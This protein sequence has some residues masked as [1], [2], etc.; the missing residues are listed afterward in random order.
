MGGASSKAARKL[1]KRAE[2]P[3]WA[4]TRTANP[5]SLAGE[6]KQPEIPRASETKNDGMYFLYSVTLKDF[7][8]RIALSSHRQ[9]FK[10][11]TAS[12]KSESSWTSASR[13]PHAN[14]PFGESNCLIARYPL[15]LKSWVTLR[16]RRSIKC[17]A[18]ELNL[19]SRPHHLEP[20]ETGYYHQH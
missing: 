5:T 15:M 9:G 4:G 3:T 18:V 6:S 17:I 16:M 11:P 12:V 19:R 7:E 10:R 1:P 2:T 13:S 14:L 8:M 20:L